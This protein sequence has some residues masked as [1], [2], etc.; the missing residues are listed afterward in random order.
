MPFVDA[1]GERKGVAAR[2]PPRRPVGTRRYS[3]S[4]AA[5]ESVAIAEC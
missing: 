5:G 2:T 1:V 3:S 4:C